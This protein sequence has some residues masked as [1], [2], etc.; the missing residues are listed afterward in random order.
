MR[1]VKLLFVALIVASI[2]FSGCKKYEEGPS[3][4]LRTKTARITGEWKIVKQLYNG[5]E[6]ALD[7]EDKSMIMD[8]QKDG[9]F[10]MKNSYGNFSGNWEFNSDKTKLII[11]FSILG[12]TSRSEATILRLTN[13]ELFTEE[14]KDGNKT[15]TEL[16]KI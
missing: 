3:L 13:K 9:I 6:V 2:A 11:S 7:A 16:E 10:I 15:R 5:V 14:V 1:K 8:I 12:Q 4:S